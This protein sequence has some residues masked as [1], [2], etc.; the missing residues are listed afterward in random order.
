MCWIRLLVKKRWV[1]FDVQDVLVTFVIQD[2]FGDT[3]LIDALLTDSRA[4]VDILLGLDHVDVT[5]VNHKGITPLH[6][7][8]LKSIP[9]SVCVCV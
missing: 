4:T 6:A 5:V 7:A 9:R 2:V 3:P 8:C 1:T